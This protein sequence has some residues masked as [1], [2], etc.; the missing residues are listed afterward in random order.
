VL[1]GPRRGAGADD[2]GYPGLREHAHASSSIGSAGLNTPTWTCTL[3][4]SA[5]AARTS[6]TSFAADDSAKKLP[7]WTASGTRAA[8]SVHQLVEPPRDVRAVGVGQRRD[9]PEPEPAHVTNR[10][11]SLPR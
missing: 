11:A 10:S 2:G 6:R 8:N 7:E 3:N 5:P 4:S 1:T 9:R